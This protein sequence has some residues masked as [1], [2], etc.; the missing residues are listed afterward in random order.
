MCHVCCRANSPW[1]SGLRAW[2]MGV[3]CTLPLDTPRIY[4][5]I[6]MGIWCLKEQTLEREIRAMHT[7]T[8][9]E[10]ISVKDKYY[11]LTYLRRDLGPSAIQSRAPN[12]DDV[13][14][15]SYVYIIIWGACT[16]VPL[17]PPALL[18]LLLLLQCMCSV[19]ACLEWITI[20]VHQ[21]NCLW[22]RAP[23]KDHHRSLGDL[24]NSITISYFN[25]EEWK[26]IFSDR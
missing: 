16:K 2:A 20:K 19:W 26:G 12:E 9:F 17:P 5:A 14:S 13:G 21:T 6:Q 15:E 25:L 10:F 24:G 3:A 7:D 11:W 23:V 1:F 22:I 4:P 18:V 8:L